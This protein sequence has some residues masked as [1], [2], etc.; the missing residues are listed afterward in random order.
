MILVK[1]EPLSVGK[2][3]KI[4]IEEQ[5]ISKKE[6]VRQFNIWLESQQE[7]GRYKESPKLTEKDLSRWTK[8]RV[9]MRH[10]K[11]EMFA[12]FFNVDVDYLACKQ[13]EK[14][15][16][17]SDF[18]KFDKQIDLAQLRK[19]VEEI[20]NEKPWLQLLRDKGYVLKE[21]PTAGFLEK[22]QIVD[23]GELLTVY[24]AAY[25]DPKTHIT[26]PEGN[27][28][29]YDRRLLKDLDAYLRFRISQ[30]KPFDNNSSGS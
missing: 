24:D 4:L 9:N 14:H 21:V 30:L 19:E 2:R 28:Y 1:A 17:E 18:S 23:Q 20:R 10:D 25:C 29:E 26:D 13:L 8:D 27:C 11:I 12:D 15:K 7:K 6:F 5:N 16:D 22:Y 3:L